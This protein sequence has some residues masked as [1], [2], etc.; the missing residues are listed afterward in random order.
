MIDSSG[1]KFVN[2]LIGYTGFYPIDGITSGGMLESAGPLLLILIKSVSLIIFIF[3]FVKQAK[4]IETIPEGFK[5]VIFYMAVVIFTLWFE[6]AVM[7]FLKTSYS[8]FSGY[9]IPTAIVSWSKLNV[10]TGNGV[11]SI[12]LTVINLLYQTM[13]NFAYLLSRACQVMQGVII[14]AVIICSPIMIPLLCIPQ[15]IN[16][17]V[18]FII[19]TSS[20]CLWPIAY[21]MV[22]LISEHILKSYEG[23]VRVYNTS[24]LTN[25]YANI[26]KNGSTP[27][28][29]KL[30][31]VAKDDLLNGASSKPHHQM[32][33]MVS[34]TY[35]G[36]D[37]ASAMVAMVF[38]VL[39]TILC[40][41]ILPIVITRMMAGSS[42]SGAAV[43]GVSKGISAGVMPSAVAAKAAKGASR[44]VVR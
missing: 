33:L 31:A 28:T 34:N 35:G 8:M 15:T 25:A 42:V 29:Q 19:I 1:F 27:S 6:A 41:V 9:D 36:I 44:M 10:I 40:Y 22:G 4:D 43:G 30:L 12:S 37:D 17:A 11:E 7:S 20:V 23:L 18:R 16:L 38:I 5:L 14:F 2:D 39:L 26:I 3:A 13:I 21:S 24:G 32:S